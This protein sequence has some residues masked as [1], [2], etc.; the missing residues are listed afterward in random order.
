MGI[1]NNYFTFVWTVISSILAYS[2]VYAHNLSMNTAHMQALDKVTGR[3]SVI[4]VPVNGEVKFGSFS[5]V[6]RDCQATPPDETPEN[7]AFV[8]VADTNREGK[9][10]NIF[11]GWMVSSS[12][13]LNSVEHPIYDVWLL[14]CINTKVDS[15]HLLTQQQLEERDN[16]ERLKENDISKEAKI[17]QEVQEQQAKQKEEAKAKQAEED[18]KQEEAEEE[19][20]RKQA[21]ED[22]IET[23]QAY[24]VIEDAHSNEGG[25]VSL[26]NIGQQNNSSI[27]QK[28]APQIEAI[29]VTT[30]SN[31]SDAEVSQLSTD[32]EI[33]VIEDTHHETTVQELDL[34]PDIEE[35]MPQSKKS[36]EE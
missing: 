10:Y 34:P 22:E 8:D 28:V 19:K 6:V 24:E 3:M 30:D 18:K 17:A 20:A 32:N 11:K 7:Y 23:Q 33:I 1:K 13:S 4:D 16:L 14:D 26:L 15:K 12:P 27:P 25:P 35:I 36:G 21:L 5:V 29:E 9:I 31:A 2:S